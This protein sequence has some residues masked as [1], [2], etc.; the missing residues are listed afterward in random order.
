MKN[1]LVVDVII[2]T[3]K[4]DENFKKVIDILKNQTYSVR[5]IRILNTEEK[6]FPIKQYESYENLSIH[7]IP[8]NQ[9]DHGG[10]RNLGASMSDGDIMVF[11]T[12]DAMPKGERFIENLIKPFDDPD[13]AASYG[14][15]LPAHDASEIEFFTRK[16]N[17]PKESFIKSK[18]D[19]EKLGIKTY[20]CSNVC[21]A[22]RKSD[23]DVLG[24][25]V[26]RA[27]FNED[28]IFA[29]KLIHA[30]K[31]IAYVAEAVVYHSHNYNN[32]EQLRRNFDLAVSQADH[33][34]IFAGIKS[35]SEGMK[36]VKNTANYLIHRKKPWLILDLFLKSGFKYL[37]YLLG[38]RYQYLP[39][40]VI[41]ACTMNKE[42]WKKR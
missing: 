25:F 32:I 42:Y 39:G 1:Q 38:K 23:Y 3:Y 33:P 5:M 22:Y 24:G 15:Q 31:K 6:Y 17:Y 20:F 10:T 40:W 28:M 16:F 34:E 41:H 4:P 30:D 9:F 29:A 14:R 19:M 37:G 2:P 26:K 13:V 35:E 27:I 18:A 36:L 11:M 7:H 12:Q 8:K 21:A